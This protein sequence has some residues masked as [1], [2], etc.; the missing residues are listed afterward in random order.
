[1]TEHL[2]RPD[3]LH[4]LHLIILV[5]RIRTRASASSG[6]RAGACVLVMVVV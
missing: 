6:R 5:E 4:V 3:S 2:L 1:M